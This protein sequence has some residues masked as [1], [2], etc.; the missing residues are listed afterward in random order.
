VTWTRAL[1][2]AR[3]VTVLT[4]FGTHRPMLARQVGVGTCRSDG[5]IGR[6]SAP[7]FPRTTQRPHPRSPRCTTGECRPGWCSGPF[8]RFTC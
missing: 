5:K 1:V 8:S 7:P 2:D 3:S 6:C 4:G